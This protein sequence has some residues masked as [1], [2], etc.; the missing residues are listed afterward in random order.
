VRHLTSLLRGRGPFVLVIDDADRLAASLSAPG[1]VVPALLKLDELT[2]LPICAVLVSRCGPE[3]FH[4]GRGIRDPVPVFFSGY[5]RDSLVDII[6]RVDGEAAAA[7]G[8]YG[9]DE[10]SVAWWCFFFFFF[11]FFFF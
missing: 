7:R 4:S 2:G 10:L 8:R 5:T 1:S 6:D 3:L 9:I 11:F